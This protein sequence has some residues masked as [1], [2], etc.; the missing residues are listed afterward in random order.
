MEGIVLAAWILTALGGLVLLTRWARARGRRPNDEPDAT[1][2]SAGMV[3]PHAT[4]ALTGLVF[5]LVVALAGRDDPEYEMRW[6]AVGFLVL[7]IAIGLAM[8]GRWR[9]S[10]RATDDELPAGVV[11]GH[12]ALA[13]L[14]LVGAIVTAFAL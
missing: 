8:F 1:D 3:A 2:I 5:W 4:F 9:A 12:G 6:L 11:Y 13:A 7:A 10:R 14:T